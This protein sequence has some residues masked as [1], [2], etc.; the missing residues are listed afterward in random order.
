MTPA[1][2]TSTTARPAGRA[3][4]GPSVSVVIAAFSSD[5]WTQLRDAVASVGAQRRRHSRPSSSST[6]TRSCSA[7][8]AV[9]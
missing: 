9:S 6:T 4:T 3:G 1:R 7:A 2:A 5:R 8:L